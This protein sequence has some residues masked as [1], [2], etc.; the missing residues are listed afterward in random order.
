ML[1][2]FIRVQDAGFLL[3]GLVDFFLVGGGRDAEEVVE[4]GRG[5]FGELD[6]VAETEDFLVWGCVSY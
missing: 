6:F 1:L 5:P 2:Y 3:V 4:G